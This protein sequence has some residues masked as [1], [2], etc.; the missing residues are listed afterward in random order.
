MRSVTEKRAL[1]A[2]VATLSI[3]VYVAFAAN[4]V[5]VL[6]PVIAPQF[7]LAPQLVGVFIGLLYV[8]SM[9]AS[10]ASAPLI[11][12]H[13]PIRL[14]QACVLIAACGL[15]LLPAAT[16]HPSA[17]VLLAVAPLV[18]GWGYGPIT[19]A[20]SQ[21]LARTALPSRMALT[22]SIKQ[23]GVPAGAALGGLLLPAL[24]LTLGWRVTLVITALLGIVVVMGSQRVRAEFDSGRPRDARGFELAGVFAPLKLLFANPLLAELAIM[25]FFYAALQMSLTSF[26][27]V[28]M[29]ES[30]GR[31]LVAAGLSLT[32]ATLGGVAGRILWGMV[33]DRYIPPRMLL[34]LLGVL[35]GAC[36]IM[37]AA[38]PADG[39]ATPLLILCVLFGAT[40]IGWNGVQLAQIAR[41]APEGQAAAVTAASG[42]VMFSGVVI[43][44]PLFGLAATVTGGYRTGFAIIGA[45]AI[46]SGAVVLIRNH[47]AGRRAAR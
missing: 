21:L 16:L 27:V 29:T 43:G 25:G 26:L 14:S 47:R 40:A 22:F 46:A 18:I 3:Q 24:A 33:A 13:G 31:S 39:P 19:P 37:T 41:H 44:P 35:A 23:T 17:V 9:I 42:F 4:A 5:A 11:T 32:F 30:L 8:G 36:S 1:I 12:R 45:A 10:L 15:L 20:S 2:L 38:Y 34:G 28:F 7:G 6:A